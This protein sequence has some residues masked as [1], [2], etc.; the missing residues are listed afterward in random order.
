M[1]GVTVKPAE[2]EPRSAYTSKVFVVFMGIL[3]LVE[4]ELEEVP[5]GLPIGLAITVEPSL[6]V[7]FVSRFAATTCMVIGHPANSIEYVLPMYF[8]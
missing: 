5:T 3:K 1:D 6:I 8:L 4:N 2:A 7:R